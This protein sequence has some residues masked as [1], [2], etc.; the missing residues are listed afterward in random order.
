V[1]R[2]LIRQCIDTSTE[3]ESCGGC[4][5]GVMASNGTVLPIYNGIK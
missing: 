1:V 4:I 5:D 3:L 2:I